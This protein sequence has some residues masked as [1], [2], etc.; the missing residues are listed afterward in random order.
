MRHVALLA[1][2]FVATVTVFAGSARA[3]DSAVFM[4]LGGRAYLGNK[5]VPRY[6]FSGAF[7][8]SSDYLAG[9]GDEMGFMVGARYDQFL[10]TPP[11][12]H[13][14]ILRGTVGWAL[15]PSGDLNL[16]Q[17][18][19]GYR[20]VHDVLDGRGGYGNAS[21]PIFGYSQYIG[22]GDM[23]VFWEVAALTYLETAGGGP[24]GLEGRLRVAYA[25]GTFEWYLRFD[26]ATGF[27]LGV[28]LGGAGAFTL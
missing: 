11:D 15:I 24:F 8:L 10:M 1:C 26:P 12:V 5:K 9:T 16:R 4:D 28:G 27:E 21:G 2:I 25:L 6:D 13:T 22:N 14:N 17:Y 23:H 18:F 20:N 7:H 19:V 3:D